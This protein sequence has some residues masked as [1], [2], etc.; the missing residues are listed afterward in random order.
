MKREEVVST[1]SS[2]S[3][4]NSAAKKLLSEQCA[5]TSN[6]RAV[7]PRGDGGSAIGTAMHV[8]EVAFIGLRCSQLGIE[9]IVLPI[10]EPVAATGGSREEHRSQLVAS[11]VHDARQRGRRETGSTNDSPP[12]HAIQAVDPGTRSWVCIERHVRCGARTL[13][14]D[15]ILEVSP[16]P[17]VAARPSARVRLHCAGATPRTSPASLGSE[18]L[19]SGVAIDGSAPSGN[20]PW[21]RAGISDA[22]AGVARRSKGQDRSR[23]IVDPV[24]GEVREERVVGGLP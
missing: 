20:E 2:K 23:I 3:R 14:E 1:A 17:G 7:V 8:V 9:Q 11:P 21:I 15:G 18:V 6:T 22:E 5:R 10:A 4:A 13:P 19:G 24:V 12:T 16:W